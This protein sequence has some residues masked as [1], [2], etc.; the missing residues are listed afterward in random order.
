MLPIIPLLR[1]FSF[2]F[3][4]NQTLEL[5][6]EP[7]F[8]NHSTIDA[9]YELHLLWAEGAACQSVRLHPAELSAMCM[10]SSGKKP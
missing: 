8:V 7:R 9:F 1:G 10:R 3:E 4:L 6:L 2:V 5:G